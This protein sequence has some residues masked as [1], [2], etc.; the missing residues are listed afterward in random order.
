MSLNVNHNKNQSGRICPFLFNITVKL[1]LSIKQSKRLELRISCSVL[2]L[3]LTAQ[4]APAESKRFSVS[5]YGVINYANFYWETDPERRAHIDVERLVIAPKL[6]IN[7]TIRLESELEFEHGGTG[8]TMNST[9]LRS[10][11]N[12]RRKSKKVARSLLRNS[13]RSLSFA[14]HSTCG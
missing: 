14:Q 3:F 5:G 11:A 10:L 2:L 6:Q 9:N 12:L 4:L 1:R 13:P 8:I 7:D